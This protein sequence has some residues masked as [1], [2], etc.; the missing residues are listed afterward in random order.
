MKFRS[1]DGRDHQNELQ[2]GHLGDPSWIFQRLLISP[3]CTAERVHTASQ[4]RQAVGTGTQAHSL[5]DMSWQ[6]LKDS[7]LQTLPAVGQWPCIVLIKC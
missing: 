4:G 7:P 1:G 5:V 6:H 2:K 3:S